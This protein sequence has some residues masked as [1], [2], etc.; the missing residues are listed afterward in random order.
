MDLETQGNKVKADVKA[1]KEKAW[2]Y[3]EELRAL[4]K[5]RH[6]ARYSMQAVEEERTA[7]KKAEEA[8]R[9]LEERMAVMKDGKKKKSG[10]NCF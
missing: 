5:E 1:W 2:A 4:H 9:Q 8:Q 7:R 3:E 6:S 10:F